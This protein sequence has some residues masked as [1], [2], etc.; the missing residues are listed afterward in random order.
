MGEIQRRISSRRCKFN[1]SFHFEFRCSI[2]FRILCNHNCAKNCKGLHVPN[3]PDY[4]EH[5][6]YKCYVFV[7]SEEL[8]DEWNRDKILN[9]INLLDVPCYTGACP[10][11]YLEKAKNNRTNYEKDGLT[12]CRHRELDYINVKNYHHIIAKIRVTN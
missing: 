4:I 8:K 5:A 9:E 3:I 2:R 11:V 10:E 6:A 1:S 7:K 12:N